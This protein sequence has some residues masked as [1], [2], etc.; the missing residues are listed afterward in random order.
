MNVVPHADCHAAH[1]AVPF[2]R[3]HSCY[4]TQSLPLTP[5]FPAPPPP[6]KTVD[7]SFCYVCRI[8]PAPCRQLCEARPTLLACPHATR[9]PQGTH[10]ARHSLCCICLEPLSPPTLRKI[11]QPPPPKKTKTTC[12]QPSTYF[13]T[14]VA[15]GRPPAGS[16]VKHGAHFWHALLLVEQGGWSGGGHLLPAGPSCGVSS[17]FILQEGKKRNRS[18]REE[19]CTQ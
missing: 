6:S 2:V 15:F 13:A 9:S 3:P 8:G 5:P 17:G 16:S 7:H 14:A 10:T 1:A 18:E 11:S 19:V 12:A 4:S